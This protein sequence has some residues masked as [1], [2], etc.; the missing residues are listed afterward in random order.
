MPNVSKIRPGGGLDLAYKIKGSRYHPGNPTGVH[1]NSSGPPPQ[2]PAHHCS[3]NASLLRR[4][5]AAN[6]R[7]GRFRTPLQRFGGGLVRL[8]ADRR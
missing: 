2:V 8:A 6:A 1:H 3:S 5:A 7:V 4:L